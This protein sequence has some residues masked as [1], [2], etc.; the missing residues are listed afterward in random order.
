MPK[1]KPSELDLVRLR[2]RNAW[3]AAR[4]GDITA[5]VLADRYY[6]QVLAAAEDQPDATRLVMFGRCAVL[7]EVMSDMRGWPTRVRGIGR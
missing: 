1:P 7:L 2:C 4:A 5:A 6:A 3:Q